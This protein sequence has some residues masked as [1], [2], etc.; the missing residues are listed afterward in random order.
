MG[1]IDEEDKRRGGQRRWS[2]RPAACRMRLVRAPRKERQHGLRFRAPC[3]ASMRVRG[4]RLPSGRRTFARAAGAGTVAADE[5]GQRV[6][7]EQ[8]WPEK[9]TRGNRSETAQSR[10]LHDGLR[11]ALREKR[12]RRAMRG[13]P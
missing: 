7:R 2:P 13:R 1:V 9:Q 5:N 3:T 12:R 6:L 10:A 4:Y 11:R 8:K